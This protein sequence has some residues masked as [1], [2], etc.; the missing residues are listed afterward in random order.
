MSFRLLVL[1]LF[2]GAHSVIAAGP[3]VVPVDMLFRNWNTRD[4][5]PHDRVRSVLQTRDGFV[6]LATD[7]GVVR[8]DGATFKTYGL[9][10]GLKAPVVTALRET[11]DGAIWI[12]TVGGG[13]SVLRGGRIERTYMKADGLPS[14]WVTGFGIDHAG[15]LVVA[16]LGG[17][18]NFDGT[19]IV[20]AGENEPNPDRVVPQARDKDGILWALGSGQ[21][22]KWQDNRWLGDP[23]GPTETTALC[24][25]GAGRPWVFGDGHLWHREEGKWQPHPMPDGWKGTV[26]TIAA[27]PDGTIWVTYFRKGILGFRNGAF[28]APRAANGYSPDLVE[29]VWATRDGQ[30]W[31]TS[32]NGIYWMA[33]QPIRFGTV[34]VPA[35]RVS[36]DLG[37]LLEIEPGQFL[38]ATQGNGF[39]LW[40]DGEAT[41]LNGDP[42]LMEGT[43]ANLEYRAA[44][45]AIWM[46]NTKGLYEWRPTEPGQPIRRHDLPDTHQAPVWAMAETAD[47]LWLGTG[48]GYLL[49]LQGD[50]V[51]HVDYGGGGEPIKALLAEPDGTVWVGTRGNGLFRMRGGQW[52]RLGRE[53]GLLSEVIRTLYRDPQGHLW[54]GTDGG[55]LALRLGD[56]FINVTSREGLPSDSISQ[57]ASDDQGR[58]WLG[59]HRGL[60]V[61]D[62][63]EVANLAA[64]TVDDLHPLLINRTNG[65][66][67]EEC[68]IVPPVKTH[69]GSWAFATIRG[70]FRLY[71]DDFQPDTTRPTVYLEK[72]LANGT[73]VPVKDGRIELPPGIER[74]EFEFS[75]LFFRDPDRLKFRNRLH[76]LDTGWIQAGTSRTAEYRHPGP[77]TFRFEV[78]ASTG[79]GLWSE[80]PAAVQIVIA[81]HF[82][83]TWWFMT[84]A[85]LAFAGSIV[86]LAR[87]AERKRSARR[88]EALERR[89]AV[90][91]ERA[92]I[93]RDLHDDV[94]ASLTQVA[95]QS[96]LVERNLTRRPERAG[97]YLKE[98][99]KTARETTRALDEIV[100]AVNPTQDTLDNFVSFLGAFVQDYARSAGL[101]S[102]FD[103]PGTVPALAMPPTVRHHLYLASKEIL[104]N[105]IKHAKASEVSLKVIIDDGH[106]M[107]VIRD[108]GAG[109]IET[110]AAVGA[111]GLLNLR[112]RLEQVHG[113]C[114]RTSAP[115]E[116]TA[117]E[118]RIPMDWE[119]G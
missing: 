34:N 46:G 14:D 12:G 97:E 102:R 9:R 101:R 69:D 13:A 98:I 112:S 44:D 57:I 51:T 113:T 3:A 80:T 31:L 10:D 64:G 81:P 93:A 53:S 75:G 1:L 37:G 59:T 96:Q 109:F 68:T 85:V 52:T 106:C 107:I 119:Q 108:N 116:G 78:E 38:L 16:T 104:H 30:I 72:V 54:V 2:M 4:G 49:R 88:I 42:D 100:W 95:L 118:M 60:A 11:A 36:N 24:L 103:V 92:R 50:S 5:L 74:L 83:Q 87:Q 21:L 62:G 33:E 70:F 79:N 66:I 20:S 35:S 55:G 56:R 82:W 28:I 17:V 105:V 115:G 86:F 26:N 43:V 114:T 27:A 76:G 111:D 99:F 48:Y 117:V 32:S 61:V 65:L 22:R 94:G 77:G 23:G 15:N 41:R 45:G 6:W 67:S 73:P 90:D 84:G 89:Q 40:R 71:P 8:F 29:T 47:G 39:F 91:N 58:L 25:D 110:P 7:A 63:K 18:A 19:R